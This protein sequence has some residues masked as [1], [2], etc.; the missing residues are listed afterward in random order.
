MQTQLAESAVVEVEAHYA[1]K[2]TENDVMPLTTAI[3]KGLLSPILKDDVNFVN[4]PH[5]AAERGIKVVESKSKTSEDFA[6]LIKLRVRSLE[7][8]NILSGTIFGKKMPRLI[9]INDFYLEAIPEGHNLLIYNQ[10]TPGAIGLIGSTLGR[11][12]VNIAR[13]AVGEQKDKRQNVV[14]LST[15]ISVGEDILEELRSHEQVLSVKRIEL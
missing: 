1:G 8:E 9:R 12:G 3:L 4:A 10:D 15:N 5:I 14:L 7:G 6:S 13:M 11:H 2:V